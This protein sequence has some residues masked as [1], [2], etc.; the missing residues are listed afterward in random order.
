MDNDEVWR[1]GWRMI[2]NSMNEN[3][4]IAELQ[5]DSLLDNSEEMDFKFLITGLDIKSKLEKNE[6]IAHVLSI[7]PQEVLNELCQREFASDLKPCLNISMER[8]KNESLQ[9]EVVKMYVDDQAVRGNIMDKLISKYNL[10]SPHVSFEDGSSV[11]AQNRNRLKEIFNEFGFPN[12]SLIG[13]HG[14]DG[15]FFIIQHSDGDKEWQKS[16][17]KN[18][19]EAVKNG[20]MDSQRYAYLF[21]RIKFNSGEKQRYGTQFANADPINKIVKLADTEDL[22]NLDNRRREIGLMPIEMY[23]RFMLKNFQN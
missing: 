14:M 11:D 20:D 7:Q 22:K 6:E 1:L 2:E 18:I 12:R 17:L 13:K 15:I 3:P 4:E 5:F 10:D 16:Q 23:K 21:D 8:V 19:H 9:L